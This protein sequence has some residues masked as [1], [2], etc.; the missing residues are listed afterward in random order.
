MKFTNFEDCKCD[1]DYE[2]CIKIRRI[3][4]YNK[5]EE[6]F[7]NALAKYLNVNTHTV[8]AYL[9]GEFTKHHK[10]DEDVPSEEWFA[11]ES[12]MF[13]VN[14]GREIKDEPLRNAFIFLLER[15]EEILSSGSYDD[16][17]E[18]DL[19]EDDRIHK[20]FN[21]LIE[22]SHQMKAYTNNRGQSYVMAEYPDCF[23][24]ER[25]KMIRE[26]LNQDRAVRNITS[27][28]WLELY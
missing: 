5:S 12:F 21:Q 9:R 17:Y 8:K 24:S 7:R 22:L 27:L 3:A 16:E 26:K 4:A 23:K 25:Y 13:A 19:E 18:Y 20:L 10:P 1:F 15:R 14:E 6:S 2:A 28:G 11:R